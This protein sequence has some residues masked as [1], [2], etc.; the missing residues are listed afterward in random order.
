M[1]TAQW[2]DEVAAVVS[3]GGRPDL[4]AS[5]L[6]KVRSPTMLIVGGADTEVVALNRTAFEQLSCS[7]GIKIIP[8]AS[9]LFEE[10]G[11]LEEV[12]EQALIWFR[13]HMGASIFERF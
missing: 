1:A 5:H 11:A 3:R 9:H 6:K 10:A 7:K 13:T 2:P 12:V 8:G 4:A